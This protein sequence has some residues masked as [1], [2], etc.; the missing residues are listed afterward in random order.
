MKKE[1]YKALNLRV[2]SSLID[3]LHNVSGFSISRY[4]TNHI[5]SKIEEIE[6]GKI[7]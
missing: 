5:R 3:R 7:R 4:F 1:K 6:S 2:P